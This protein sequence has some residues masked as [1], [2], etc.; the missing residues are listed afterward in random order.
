MRDRLAGWVAPLFRVDLTVAR[1]SPK[2]LGMRAH[3]SVG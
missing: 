2:L 1:E 3:S